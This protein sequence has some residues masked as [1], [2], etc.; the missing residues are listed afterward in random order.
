MRGVRN[1]VARHNRLKG[2]V[3][4]PSYKARRTQEKAALV[5]EAYSEMTQERTSQDLLEELDYRIANLE[6]L[7]GAMLQAG[8]DSDAEEGVLY[9][10][11][12]E[13]EALYERIQ[14]GEE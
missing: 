3:H 8:Y 6:N 7:I 5:E 11:V 10:L 12:E 13:R 14:N 4:G 1:P 9:D 2:G